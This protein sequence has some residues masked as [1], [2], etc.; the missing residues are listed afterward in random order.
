[1]KKSML[2]TG[3]GYTAAGLACLAAALAAEL[4]I[5]PLLWGLFG[6]G[7]GA[8]VKMIWQ[9]FHWSSP[10]RQAEYAARMKQE[11]IEL[12]DERKVMLRHRSGW[13]AY[14]LMLALYCLLMLAFS[15]FSMLGY[16]EPVARFAVLGL[17]VLLAVQILLGQLAYRHYEKQM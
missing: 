14:I 8:G 11:S 5:E 15:V 10:E 3:I 1:M 17:A 16:F 6:A 2:Y 7:V 4:R 9:Y 13:L 12:R